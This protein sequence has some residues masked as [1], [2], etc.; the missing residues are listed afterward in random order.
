MTHPSAD[1]LQRFGED[2][3][4]QTFD[5]KKKGNRA[6]LTERRIPAEDLKKNINSLRALNDKGAGIYFCVN[7]LRPK[8]RRV[9]DNIEAVTAFFL[10]LDGSPVKP[11]IDWQLQPNLVVRTSEDRYHCYWILDD[12]YPEAVK[13]FKPIQRWLADKFNGDKSISDLCRVMRIPGFNNMKHEPFMVTFEER[14]QQP[15]KL[16][17]IKN[18]FEHSKTDNDTARGQSD[19][20]GPIGVSLLPEGFD[21]QALRMDAGGGG[22]KNMAAD[23]T[24]SAE[25][26]RGALLSISADDYEVW[27][28]VGMALQGAA[29]RE[30]AELSQDEAFEWWDSWSQTSG[31]YDAAIMDEKWEGLNARGEAGLGTVFELA[32]QQG[33]KGQANQSW[34]A[35]EVREKERQRMKPVASERIDMSTKEGRLKAAR[36]GLK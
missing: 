8:A 28:R 19:T 21:F 30:D 3:F 32:Q 6:T 29:V 7:Q 11:V 15:Y 34:T 14:R 12:N 25:R 24:F 13:L 10:D 1:F 23:L 17:E 35:E 33:W 36:I 9:S 16:E 26:L 4:I 5:D 27:L 2:F 20:N 18:V 22:I 31:K